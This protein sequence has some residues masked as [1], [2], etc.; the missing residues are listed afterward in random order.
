MPA[1]LIAILTVL[2][3]F[4]AT[5]SRTD[6]GIH[7]PK[8]E[9]DATIK[10]L[11]PNSGTEQLLRMV[12]VGKLQVGIAIMRREAKK[13]GGIEHDELTEVYYILEGSGTLTTGRK[14]TTP[15][16]MDPN[17]HVVKDLAGPSISSPEI[18]DGHSQRFVAGDSII[19]PAGVGH[20]FSQLDSAVNY[21]VI[22]IDPD[23]LLPIK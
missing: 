23:K 7:L 6:Y 8:A 20:W 3:A 1:P 5:D 14:L 18:T 22:R 12:D 10:A 21:L 19:I 15:S 17:G 2:T 4:A 13:Q 9:V 16:R 11:P